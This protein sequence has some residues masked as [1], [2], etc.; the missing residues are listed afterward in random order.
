MSPSIIGSTGLYGTS[1]NRA[2]DPFL[3]GLGRKRNSTRQPMR[4]TYQL[5]PLLL[6]T[7]ARPRSILFAR[8]II[9]LKFASL[10]ACSS[11]ALIPATAAALPESV[12]PKPKKTCQGLRFAIHSEIAALKPRIVRDSRRR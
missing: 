11:A 12:P 6:I 5:R 7:F 8:R 1:E 2:S 10:M 9:R 4:A 3:G